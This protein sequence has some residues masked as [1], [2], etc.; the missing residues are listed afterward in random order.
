MQFKLFALAAAFFSVVSPVLAV[1]S[2]E[3]GI[4]IDTSTTA[5]IDASKAVKSITT[6][7]IVTAAPVSPTKSCSLATSTK[8]QVGNL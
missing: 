1:T 4:D 2:D 7:N 8:H 6:S 3:L 5:T